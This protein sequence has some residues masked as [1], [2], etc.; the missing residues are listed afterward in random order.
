MKRLVFASFVL[1]ALFALAA[2]VFAYLWAFTQ[3]DEFGAAAGISCIAAVSF[4]MLG[5]LPYAVA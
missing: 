4:V 1:A 5:T 2:L 3:S